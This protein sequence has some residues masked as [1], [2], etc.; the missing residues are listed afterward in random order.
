MSADEPS[1]PLR[2]L[3]LL[4][5]GYG[6]NYYAVKNTMRADDL[7]IR[8]K[9]SGLLGQAAEALVAQEAAYR[10]KYVPPSTREQPFPPRETLEVLQDLD[11]LRSTLLDLAASVRGMPVPAQD[12]TWWRLRSERA[13]LDQLLRF[14]LTLVE[15]ATQ[16]ETLVQTFTADTWQFEHPADRARAALSA[17][18]GAVRERRALLQVHT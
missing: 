2:Q 5:T 15:Q 17:L 10:R 9:V 14:D 8:Q 4:L 3:E 12:R 11:R 13:L 18:E 1:A 6:Y 7:L 16:I